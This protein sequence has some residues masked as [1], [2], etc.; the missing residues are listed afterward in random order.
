MDAGY[1]FVEARK[2]SASG[3]LTGAQT[4]LH[5]TYLSYHHCWA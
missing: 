5:E 1:S 2:E 3:R 4:K